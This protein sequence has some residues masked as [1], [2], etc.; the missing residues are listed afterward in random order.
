MLG[1]GHKQFSQRTQ[2]MFE[3]NESMNLE[4]LLVQVRQLVIHYE[5][6]CAT[7][8]EFE[9]VNSYLEALEEIFEE[10]QEEIKDCCFTSFR[11]KVQ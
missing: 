6:Y 11:T 8:P 4:R 10:R 9:M 2:A 1:E 7:Y 3:T 5:R